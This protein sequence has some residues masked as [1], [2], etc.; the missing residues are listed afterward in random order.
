MFGQKSVK[1]M[2]EFRAGWGQFSN[3]CGW[4]WLGTVFKF[5]GTDPAEGIDPGEGSLG[6]GQFLN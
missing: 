5:G 6:L 1:K 3:L 4:V 2:N